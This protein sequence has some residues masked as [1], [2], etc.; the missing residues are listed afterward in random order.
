MDSKDG[1]RLTDRMMMTIAFWGGL[2]P[3]GSLLKGRKLWE[4]EKVFG[5]IVLEKIQLEPNNN[6]KKD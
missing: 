5:E 1:E 6:L 4:K 2:L 3:F